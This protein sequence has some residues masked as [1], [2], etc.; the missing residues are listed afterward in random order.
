MPEALYGWTAGTL[1]RFT[2]KEDE[3]AGKR[4]LV[5][6]SSTKHHGLVPSAEYF[7]NRQ[8]FSDNTAAY[9][10]VK[11]SWFAYATNHLSEGSIGLQSRFDEACV[12]PIYTVFSCAET[13]EPA[14]LYWLLRSPELI[15]AYKIREQASVDRRGAV[16][17]ADFAKIEVRIPPLVEQRKI[18]EILDTADESIHATDRLLAKL[19]NTK[20]GLLASLI[21]EIDKQFYQR[22]HDCIDHI[23]A[24]KSPDVPNRPAEMDEWGVLK[25][26]AVRPWGLDEAENKVLTRPAAIN[27][28]HE[29]RAGDLLITRANTPQL[30]GLT[31][32]VKSTRPR[33]LLSD[34]TLRLA[35]KSEAASP[36]YLNYVLGSHEARKQIEMSGTGSSGS[37]KNISQNEIRSVRIPLPHVTEQRRIVAIIE[38]TERA[39]ARERDKLAKLRKV[40]RGL[41]EDLLTGRVRMAVD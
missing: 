24:G 40:K 4:K 12:S 20:D 38:S 23:E 13:V 22:L 29:V 35:V 31:C 1:A 14:Y 21:S 18:A 30:V 28:H 6:L 39:V 8:I 17:Y 10:L 9:R 34:K 16:R 25:V 41:M 26:S 36:Q 5:V 2:Q 27:P 32:Y 3:R 19:A 7:K 33:L 37:M 15:N 11:R